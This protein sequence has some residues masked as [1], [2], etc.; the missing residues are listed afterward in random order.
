MQLTRA[1]YAAMSCLCCLKYGKN[2][3]MLFMNVGSYLISDT[4][5]L[6][7]SQEYLLF[8]AKIAISRER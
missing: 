8:T 6:S 1:A 5:E 7:A 3:Y 4:I 2:S